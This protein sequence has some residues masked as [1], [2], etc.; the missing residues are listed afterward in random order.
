MNEVLDRILIN[1][2]RVVPHDSGNVM[3]LENGVGHIVRHQRHGEFNRP[4]NDEAVY[5]PLSRTPSLRQIYET[6]EPLLIGD[7]ERLV[8]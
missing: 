4:V 3:L 1:V 5:L 8:A 7:T 6:G 2:A